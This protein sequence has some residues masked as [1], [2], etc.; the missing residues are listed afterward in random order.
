ML[1]ALWATMF[2]T[3]GINTRLAIY[4]LRLITVG[5]LFSIF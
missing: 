1:C 3:R 2:W 5:M 4:M